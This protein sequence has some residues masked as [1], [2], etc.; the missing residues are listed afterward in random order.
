M[1][2]VPASKSGRMP[3]LLG[4]LASV[5]ILASLASAGGDPWKSKPYQQWDDKDI[6][7][8]VR[9][10]PWSRTV[11]IEATWE[12]LNDSEL[13]A[14]NG[15]TPGATV[16]TQGSGGAKGG[17]STALPSEHSTARTRG[18]DASFSVYWMSSRTMRAAMA[19]KSV[20]HAGKDPAEA[21]KF[22]NQSLDTYVVLLQCDDMAP[23][24][25]NDEK[26]FQS[27]ASLIVK[28][29]KQ[30]IDPSQV[31]F[32]RDKDGKKV[33]GV[34]FTF[35]KKGPNGEETISPQEK[36]VEFD[37]KIGNSLLKAP[38]EPQKMDDA[39]GSDL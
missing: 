39:K 14:V 38:F 32:Q 37:C 7:K 33:V 10:S 11:V 12:P 24:M 34:L 18:E 15:T 36:G 16:G 2:S 31:A 3:A 21:D 5:F 23:F 20:L 27:R 35:P 1:K 4:L 22:V 6:E 30:K 26:F 29:T 17:T 9:F 25:R 19:R 8:V 13:A 28:S